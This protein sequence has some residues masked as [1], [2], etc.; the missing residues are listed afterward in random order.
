MSIDR[1]FL[2]TFGSVLFKVAEYA[3][4]GQIEFARVLPIMLR[5]LDETLHEM[6]GVG[7]DGEFT[8]GVEASRGEIDRPN[9]RPGLVG[10]QHL[11]VQF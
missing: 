6:L 5:H 1:E 7:L 9:D 8:P 2:C 3:L 4:T 10:E 11:A